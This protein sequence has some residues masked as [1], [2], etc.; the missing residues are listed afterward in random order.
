MTGFAKS[1]KLRLEDMNYF[2]WRLEVI[3]VLKIA[4]CAH[5]ICRDGGMAEKLYDMM[6]QWPVAPIGMSSPPSGEED[7]AL[8]SADFAAQ[9]GK[10]DIVLAAWK[11]AHSLRRLQLEA[12]R[13]SISNA[14]AATCGP[15]IAFLVDNQ[16]H[17]L[18]VE[19]QPGW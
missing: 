4:N 8:V 3:R 18:N 10:Y 16:A 7:G 9:Q 19:W 11:D 6:Y 12:D 15:A 2:A 14:I 17:N 1:I 5:Y 13:I